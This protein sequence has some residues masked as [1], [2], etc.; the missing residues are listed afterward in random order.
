[1][2]Y[3]FCKVFFHQF[4]RFYRCKEEWSDK[5]HWMELLFSLLYTVPLKKIP[6]KKPANMLIKHNCQW[7]KVNFICFREK[8]NFQIELNWLELN[9]W[10]R[11]G[12]IYNLD[13]ILLITW[14]WYITRP[15][16]ITWHDIKH[17]HDILH[18]RFIWHD[19]IYIYI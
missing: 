18:N 11:H 4:K 16:Y 12:S 7:C 15:F 1:M 17:D 10:D 5:P 9:T 14:A 13:I 2:I 3:F 8:L 19:M 6:V